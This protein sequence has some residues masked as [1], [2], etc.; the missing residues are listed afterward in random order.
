MQ[1]TRSSPGDF[2]GQDGGALSHWDRSIEP[3][4]EGQSDPTWRGTLIPLPHANRCSLKESR[5]SELGMKQ[6]SLGSGAM[7]SCEWLGL[8]VNF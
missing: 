1:W 7:A 4:Q 3:T 5:V 6:V 8:S 2:C